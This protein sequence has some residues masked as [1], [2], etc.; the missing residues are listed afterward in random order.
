MSDFKIIYEQPLNELM[1]VSLRIEHLLNQINYCYS[2]Y[3]HA[4][5]TRQIIKLIVDLMAVVDRPDLKSKLSKEYHRF[6][7]Y[8]SQLC[9]VPEISREKLQE[10]VTQLQNVLANY[11]LRVQGKFLEPLR[12]NEF[13]TNIRHSLLSPGGDSPIDA[14]D[15]FYLVNQPLDTQKEQ[16]S[17][18]L[19]QLKDIQ[20]PIEKLLQII[21]SSSLPVSLVAQKGFYYQPLNAQ[22]PLQLIRIGL[23]PQIKLYPEISVGKHRLICRF[24]IPSIADRPRQTTDDISFEL[25]CCII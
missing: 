21:R 3:E 6:I 22:L 5:N 14:P 2:H 1:R 12:N 4:T 20:V 8:F 7:Y 16:L 19:N 23:L 11:L 13:L 24:M 9:D 25:T 18:W 10:T 15:Y 17:L